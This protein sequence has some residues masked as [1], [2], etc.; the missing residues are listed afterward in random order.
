MIPIKAENLPKP[1]N[2]E[3]AAVG[4]ERWRES[5]DSSDAG[6][7]MRA[8]ASDPAGKAVLEAI[9]GNSPYLG[10]LLVR[11][12]E[13]AVKAL[14]RGPDD[15]F[16][17]IID[18]LHADLADADSAEKLMP[19]LRQAKNRAALLIA[20]ADIADIWP[21]GRVTRALSDLAD[22][23]LNLTVRGLL[24]QLSTNGVFSLPP[25][26]TPEQESGLVILALG[27]LGAQELNYSSDIDIMILYEPDKFNCPNPDA[28]PQE[29]VRLARLLMRVM[30]E[31]TADGYVFRTDLRL[32][33]DPGATPLAVPIPA[34]ETYYES[35][36]QNWERAAMIR[37]RACAGD[38]EAGD[39]FLQHLRPFIWRKHLDFAA[40]QDIHSIKRQITSYRGGGTIAVNGH[41]VKLGRGGIREIEFFAQTQ[42]L[43]WGGRSPALRTSDVCET[44]QALAD[45][46]RIEP[47]TAH[48]MQEAYCYLRRLEHRLQMVDDHQTHALPKTDEQIED[49]AVFAGYP[50]AA[51][52]RDGLVRRLTLVEKNY[53]ELFEEAPDLG[54]AGT[55]V[56]TGSEDHPE[57][58]KTLEDMGFSDGASVSTMIR[59]WHHGR[60]RATRSVDAFL[61]GLPAGVQLFSLFYANPS[62]LDLVAEIMGDAPKLAERLSR[63]PRLLDHVLSHDF[64]EQLAELDTLHGELKA[65]L[66]EA[67]DFQDVL[68][69][70]RRWTNDRKFQT[71][72]QILQGVTDG[73]AAGPTY[74]AIAETVIADLWPA[75]E[76]EFSGPGGDHGTVPG[77][78]MVVIAFGKL[79]GR[80]LMPGS[81][82]D[83]VFV[84][85]VPENVEESDGNKPLATSV[86]Y[87]R[88]SQ[89]VVGAIEALTGEGRLYE[90]DTRLRP[91]GGKGPAASR[92]ESFSRYYA[93]S[94]WT[95]EHM[96]LTRARAFAGCPDLIHRLE[97]EIQLILTRPRDPDQLVID[98]AKMRGRIAKE[99]RGQSRWDIK[100]RRGGLVDAEFMVQYL[101]LRHASDHPEILSS[102]AVTAIDNLTEAKLIDRDFAT[103]IG[104]AVRLWH[105]VQTVLR[106]TTTDNLD[107]EGRA[108][109]PRKAL[110]RAVGVEDFDA[111]VAAMEET[112]ASVHRRFEELI[113]KPAAEAARRQTDQA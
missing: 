90:V 76:E 82:V 6:E 17:E 68:E 25:G 16:Q 69:V 12:P 106:L 42:Q 1:A 2:P 75:V 98:V 37:A 34:A 31:R 74:S 14:H 63:N 104:N 81:D 103:E 56:F 4:M 72:V 7:T 54:G 111:L 66:T 46:G 58:I 39:A 71:G 41:N 15:V 30:D 97:E 61:S 112:A 29:M 8:V 95:W 89:R 45:H 113:D 33:P 13:I 9:F 50:D 22:V 102:N 67:H 26:N 5:A 59:R 32:R 21:V 109:G 110:V 88:L 94:A 101:Q 105:R 43:I 91:S 77:G 64:F 28:L 52:F 10:Q 73:H 99:H 84:Y 20:L 11:N 48:D 108:E 27:K 38:I 87:M 85:D 40:I 35:V 24:R 3:R 92:F 51:A 107:V 49:I 83:L 57:T 93:E 80:E 23:S 36:G 78:G 70:T 19:G 100:H 18:Q 96:A 65:A 86:Y 53:A 55:L 62:L 79:G 44:L 47:S 60:Y